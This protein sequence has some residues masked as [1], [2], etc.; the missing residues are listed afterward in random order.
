MILNHLFDQ[1]SDITLSEEHQGPPGNHRFSYE[2][3]CI[4]R[5][6]ESLHLNFVPK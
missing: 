3:A 2:P 6:L 1:A 5:R 4:I